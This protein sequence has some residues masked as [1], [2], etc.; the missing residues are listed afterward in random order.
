[1]KVFQRNESSGYTGVAPKYFTSQLMISQTMSRPPASAGASRKK[2]LRAPGIAD[3]ALFSILYAAWCVR[4][5]S[6]RTFV[7]Q[8]HHGNSGVMSY[9]RRNE[10][11]APSL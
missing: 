11:I 4:V 9:I 2:R 6:V 5:P 1:L 7:P 8:L 3:F 10:R